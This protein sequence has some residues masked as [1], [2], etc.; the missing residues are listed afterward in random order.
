M[1]EEKIVED[2][3]KLYEEM[4]E[5]RRTLESGIEDMKKTFIRFTVLLFVAFI[6]DNYN[7]LDYMLHQDN[8]RI[9]EGKIEKIRHKGRASKKLTITYNL[10]GI[11][12]EGTTTDYNLGDRVGDEITIIIKD[13]KIGRKQFVMGMATFMALF[14]CV[15][16]LFGYCYLIIY[17]SKKQSGE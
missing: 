8:Y 3:L 10:D 9:C 15:M 4:L 11:I 6:L 13:N 2:E 17:R 14:A 5:Q 16:F 1:E 7:Y 12:Y